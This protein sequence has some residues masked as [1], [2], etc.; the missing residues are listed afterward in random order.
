MN[1][2]ELFKALYAK[3]EERFEELKEEFINEE[4]E[5]IIEEF[6]YKNVESFLE[7]EFSER[8]WCGYTYYQKPEK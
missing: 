6:G 5:E 4:H 7:S 1:K 2:E 3:F 8:V